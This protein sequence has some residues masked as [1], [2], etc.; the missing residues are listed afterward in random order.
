MNSIADKLAELFD[1]TP[2]I[3]PEDENE[4]TT[5]KV[6]DKADLLNDEENADAIPVK[7]KLRNPVSAICFEEKYAGKVVSRVENLDD[8]SDENEDHLETSS[9]VDN[10]EDVME[11]AYGVEDNKEEHFAEDEASLSPAHDLDDEDEDEEILS[12]EADGNMQMFSDEKP[13]EMLFS[14]K[15]D[16]K[17][18]IGI[19]D[20][21]LETRIKL[22]KLLVLSNKLPRS[23]VHTQFLVT[24]DSIGE[25]VSATSQSLSNLCGTL[26]SLQTSL[27]NKIDDDCILNDSVL[28]ETQFN[29]KRLDSHVMKRCMVTRKRRN[30][31]LNYWYDKTKLLSN[32]VDK[33]FSTFERPVVEQI[34]QILA[35]RDRLIKRTRTKRSEYYVLGSNQVDTT[36]EK[37]HDSHLTDMDVELFDDDDFYQQLLQQF[38]QQKT[39]TSSTDSH[40]LNRQWLKVQR[41]HSKIKKTV[42]TKASKGRKVRY[43]VHPKLVSFMSSHDKSSWSHD[44]RNQLVRSVFGKTEFK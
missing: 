25:L 14:K 19:N 6:I 5:A 17:F 35:D 42:D 16:T 43:H 39:M 34:E 36:S 15:A 7:S 44:S 29:A 11:N 30:K 1:P 21:M 24:D 20:K 26:L 40:S 13:K 10:V 4:E 37:Q 41:M 18:Q 27:C 32:K 33:S 3:D 9:D 12:D 8:F 28:E 2:S 38:I 22:Q 23:N 31:T